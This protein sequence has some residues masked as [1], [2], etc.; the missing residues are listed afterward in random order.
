M[1]RTPE[2]PI[3][4]GPDGLASEVDPRLHQLYQVHATTLYRFLSPWTRGDR[5][6]AEDLVW[7]TIGRASRTLDEVDAD[8]AA[9][10]LWLLTLARRVAIEFGRSGRDRPVPSGG[11]HDRRSAT[12]SPV[13]GEVPNEQ[14]AMALMRLSPEYRRV[15][16][17]LF[18]RGRSVPETARLL[19]IPE[20]AVTL[21]AYH[22]LRTLGPA[23]K[24]M[25][26]G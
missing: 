16:V 3:D 24:A 6:A 14:V 17:E 11:P 2:L 23:I 10:Q 4:A 7:E 1:M 18:Y 5:C 12:T 22:A 26:A 8:P 13:V 15:I 19:A 9:V 25:T 21:R 20:T